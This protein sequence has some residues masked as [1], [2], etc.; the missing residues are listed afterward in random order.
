MA[1]KCIPGVFCIENMTLAVLLFLFIV[2]AYMYYVFIV[3]VG[4][5]S[6]KQTIVYQP[7]QSLPLMSMSNVSSRAP[8][9][10]MDPYGPPFKTDGNYF[11]SDSGSM[12]LGFHIFHFPNSVMET[13]YS[14][15]GF[16]LADLDPYPMDIFN[17][18][19]KCILSPSWD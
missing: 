11:R 9:V 18:F 4:E 8:N 14:A 1:K 6:N 13:C 12:N 7:I 2:L 19:M 3:K 17:D 15:T 10:I 5:N 16:K